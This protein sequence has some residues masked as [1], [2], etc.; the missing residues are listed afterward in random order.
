MENGRRLES[1]EIL[2]GGELK[3]KK[4]NRTTYSFHLEGGTVEKSFRVGLKKD[5]YLLSRGDK[6]KP[7]A[8]VRSA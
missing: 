1:F 4:E 8:N 2:D 6:V 3:A 5:R 7:L